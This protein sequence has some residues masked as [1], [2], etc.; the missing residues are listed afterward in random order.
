[1]SKLLIPSI[2]LAC[3]SIASA[4]TADPEMQGPPTKDPVREGLTVTLSTG[5]GE[6][7]LIPE[8]GESSRI[9]G[10]SF[11]L[12]FGAAFSQAAAF[13]GVCTFVSGTNDTNSL[14]LGGNLKFYT[15][16]EVFIR[17]GAG[18][19]NTKL[20]GGMGSSERFW[21]PGGLFSVG[22]EWFQ[23]RDIGLFAE[24]ETVV[25]KPVSKTIMMVEVDPKMTV[26]NIQVNFG[27]TWY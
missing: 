7:H 14:L 12:R 10:P 2:V 23:L 21:G 5:P 9:E 11:S 13:E 20:G 18:V 26:L 15:R 4:E 24:L 19:A 1:M 17:A 16:D 27:I 22:Y 3:T 6:Y 25:W 8:D